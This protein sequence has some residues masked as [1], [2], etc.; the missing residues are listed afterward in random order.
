MQF[1]QSAVA[2]FLFAASVSARCVRPSP[3][4]SSSS[5][6]IASIETIA[7]TSTYA[8]VTQAAATPTTTSS[9][10]SSSST[11]VVTTSSSAAATTTAASSSSS[12]T[13]DEENALAAHN[14]ARSEVGE[15]ALTW[16]DSLVSAAQS[17][18]DTLAAQ[19]PGQLEHGSTGENLYWQS[20]GDDPYTAAANAWIAEKA[21]YNGEAIPSSGD[22]SWM[23]YCKFVVFLGGLFD[24]LIRGMGLCWLISGAKQQRKLSGRLPRSLVWLSLRMARV[25]PMLSPG[26]ILLATSK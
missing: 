17:W 2:A 20:G 8:P 10:S 5:S 22:A 13:T 14:T 15:A 6:A 12:L 18:A 23:H 25:A 19:G 1:S 9:S 16:D 7:V 24:G 4:S 3:S 21:D 11:A 26:T